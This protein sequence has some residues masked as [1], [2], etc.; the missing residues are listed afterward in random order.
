VHPLVSLR[1]QLNARPH[2]YQARSLPVTPIK[3]TATGSETIEGLQVLADAVCPFLKHSRPAYAR[4]QRDLPALR[5]T[6]ISIILHPAKGLPLLQSLY[7]A[8]EAVEQGPWAVWF[9]PG[10]DDA[11][12]K[13]YVVEQGLEGRVVLGGQCVLVSGDAIRAAEGLGKG[14]GKSAL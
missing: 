10:A 9:Q 14:G 4:L 7:P 13:A 5:Q 1:I 11:A 8:G 3:P 6:A 12:I 2:R